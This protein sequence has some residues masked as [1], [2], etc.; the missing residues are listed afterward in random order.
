MW[1]ALIIR[2]N[3]TTMKTLSSVVTSTR[4]S[5]HVLVR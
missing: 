2:D 5:R 3:L 1:E 4:N